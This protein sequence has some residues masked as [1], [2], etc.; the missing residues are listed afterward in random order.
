MSAHESESVS[1]SSS[2]SP[3]EEIV[4]RRIRRRKKHK[5]KEAK[6]SPKP[7]KEQ[8]PPKE[9]ETRMEKEEVK[10]PEAAAIPVEVEK[11]EPEPL[12]TMQEHRKQRKQ[13]I[14]YKSHKGRQEEETSSEKDHSHSLKS[15]KRKRKGKLRHSPTPSASSNGTSSELSDEVHME[16]FTNKDLFRMLRSLDEHFEGC[17][18]DFTLPPQT[19]SNLLAGDE[20]VSGDFEEGAQVIEGDPALQIGLISLE[21]TAH[22][23]IRAMGRLASKP[24]EAADCLLSALPLLLHGTARVQAHLI[25]EAAGITAE[26]RRKEDLKVHVPREAR[27]AIDASFFPAGA[28]AIGVPGTPPA[29]ASAVA[30]PAAATATPTAAH[31]LSG[32]DA[33]TATPGISLGNRRGAHGLPPPDEGSFHLPIQRRR[34]RRPSP[35]WKRLLPAPT[36]REGRTFPFPTP[37]RKPPRIV[38]EDYR[39]E[40]P[41]AQRDREIKFAWDRERRK[42]RRK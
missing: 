14:L 25:L 33:P 24:E 38:R 21:A 2:S 11:Q 13:E 29:P 31:A 30:A 42:A 10:P 8:T 17:L 39:L 12:V 6:K 16:D 28:G 18:A 22:F 20:G 35:S 36:P 32:S 3:R 5:Q 40:N 26:R 23:L 7:S 34:Q 27:A 4:V 41:G 9:P 15:T 19:I 37:W 1:E